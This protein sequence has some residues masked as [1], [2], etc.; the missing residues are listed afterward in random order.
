MSMMSL[1]RHGQASF[2]ATDYDQ[3]STQGEEQSRL[4]GRYWGVH[5]CRFD[6]VYTGPRLRQ[7]QT[8]EMI[9]VS[10]RHAGGIWPDPVML[11]GLDEYDLQGFVKHMAPA[12]AA[13][14]SVFANLLEIDQKIT[15]P[16][17]R[18]RSFQAMFEKLLVHWQSATEPIDNVETWPV[19]RQRVESTIRQ[20]QSNASKSSRVAIVTSGGFIGTTVQSVLSA[21][22]RSA[23]ELNWRV[24]NSSLTELV[25]TPDRLTLDSFNAVPHLPDPS[26]WTYR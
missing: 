15:L 3:L 16:R 7:R 2:L 26:Q 5:G 6:A 20:I 9:G 13:K 25:F 10:I 19:F 23:L 18:H 17:E 1:V 8:A 4:L 22:D 21:P 12:L 24:R 11:P 14:D